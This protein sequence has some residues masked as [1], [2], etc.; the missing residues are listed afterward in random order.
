MRV[1]KKSDV[2]A[3]GIPCKELVE[4]LDELNIGAFA[5]DTNGK[6]AV[7]NYAGQA[8]MGLKQDEVLG[9]E[10]RE[11]FVGV[12]C[13]VK[14]LFGK[15]GANGCEAAESGPGEKGRE[16]D[17]AHLLLTRLATPVYDARGNPSGCLTLL[18]NHAPIA[19]LIER[20]QYEERSLKLILD[21]LDLGIFTVNR[22][23][24]ITFFN[25]EAET[26]SGFNRKKILGKHFPVL[27]GEEDSEKVGGMMDA[28]A[29]GDAPSTRH[30]KMTTRGGDVIPIRLNYM[31]L[32][33]EKGTHMGGLAAFHDLTLLRQFNQVISDRYTFHDMIGKSP[34]M[35]RIFEKVAV[36]A[37]TDATV[38]IEGN[39]GTGKGV[40]A[41]V[42]HSA[43]RRAHRPFVKVNCSAIPDNLIESELF[44]YMKGAFTGAAR[45]KPGRFS[46]AHTGTIFLD[47]IGE[48]SFSLQAKLLGVLED[49]AFYPLGSRSLR[50]VDV[51]I[52]AAT[53][54]N[55][56]E[57]VDKKRF[58]EDLYYRLNIFRFT[59]P[60]LRERRMDLP[61]LIRHI[62]RRLCAARGGPPAEVSEGAMEILL[63]LDYPGNVR[64]LENILEHALIVS[65]GDMI[66]A[67]HLPEHLMEPPSPRGRGMHGRGAPGPGKQGGQKAGGERLRILRMLERFD[68]HRIKTARALGMGR[69][70][71]WRKMKQ[72]DLCP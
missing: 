39:T 26:V 29:R 48:L 52:L 24:Y 44:G 17:G 70:T 51:R 56:R 58:R 65:P 57:L 31:S 38:L 36:V 21:S 7:I 42:I 20:V 55:L 69:S 32:K 5:A 66:Q 2:R 33:N 59:L 53:N 62:L 22:G 10:C 64:E 50:K 45:D 28:V 15:S 68:G 3:G 9:R 6:I 41:R 61:L 54:R 43:G 4:L 37:E 72:Y 23:G 49:R 25:R 30:V 14:C 47:E 16:G 63:K 18:Q 13:M 35:K 40:L 27:F 46:D 34:E 8:L 1:R 71:L 12:P 60:D 19:E 67:R 11:V